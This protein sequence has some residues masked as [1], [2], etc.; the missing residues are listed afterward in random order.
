MIRGLILDLDGT[1]V[2]SNDAHARAWVRAFAGEGLNIPFERVRP[3]MGMGGDQLIPTLTD[4][5]PSSPRAQALSAAWLRHFREQELPVL[6]PMPGARELVGGLRSRG[7]RLVLGTSSD[8]E[9]VSEL[10]EIAG[11]ADLLT[12]RTTASDVAESKPEPDIIHAALEKLQLGPQQVLMVG[13]TRFDIE[14][15][16][17]AGVQTVALLCGGQPRRELKGALALFAGPADWAQQLDGP[18]LQ[19]G[20]AT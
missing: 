6:R 13:D 10:L 11:V 5:S 2:D 3:L 17:R 20:A 16:Q 1:L 7:Y 4:L 12:Q 8:E 9:L 18:P 14:A 19:P 15:A